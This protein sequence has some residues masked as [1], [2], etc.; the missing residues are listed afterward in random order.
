[1]ATK[2]FAHESANNVSVDWYTP[3]HIFDSLELQFDLDP[4]APKGGVPWIPAAKHYSVE[5]DGLNA[6][7]KGLVW[8]NPPYGKATGSWL[9]KMHE[10]RNGVALLFAR[11]DCAWFHNY[12]SKA[13]G[14]LFLRGR[15]KFVDGLGVT[16]GSGAGSGSMLVAWGPKAYGALQKMSKEGYL[17]CAE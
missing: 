13:D 8:L 5:D 17:V 12:I 3:K 6:E 16:G 15:V 14:I 9:K 11:T 2:G 10:H 1:M 4:C 7:W